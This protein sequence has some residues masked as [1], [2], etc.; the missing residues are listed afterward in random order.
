MA[1]R[2]LDLFSGAGGCSA[3]YQAAG[4]ETVGVDLNANALR[5]YPGETIRAD[6]MSV[7]SDDRLLATFDV[8]HASPPCQH[9]SIATSA[10]GAR[11]AHP[12]L[13]PA[14]TDRLAEIGLP[15]VIEN[16]PGA[17]MDSAL[18]LCG[19]MFDLTAHDPATGETLAL[20]RHRLFH[21]DVFLYPPRECDHSLPVGGVY[22]GGSTDRNRAK[23]V[24]RGG[25][26][27]SN[28]VAADLMEIEWMTHKQLTQAIPPA[29]TE[30][31]GGLIMDA[32]K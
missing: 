29:Y 20:R 3:G 28:A 7:L 26:T 19:S 9:Y 23:H 12:D 2:L 21:S 18:I 24:R 17:P 16:V 25:Y 13:L 15:H 11:A 14:V 10:P 32:L 22:G 27:P 1:P 8:I 4:F 6:A 5:R 30:W 31:I